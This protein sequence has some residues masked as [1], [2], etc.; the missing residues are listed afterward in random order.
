VGEDCAGGATDAAA[1]AE[2]NRPLRRPNA[3]GQ[4]QPAVANESADAIELAVG[5]RIAAESVIAAG[6]EDG[7]LIAAETQY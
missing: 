5:E 6:V 7:V 1:A 4:R 2:M 3:G